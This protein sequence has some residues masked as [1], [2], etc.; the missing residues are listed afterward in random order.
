MVAN[1]PHR[2]VDLITLNLE[3]IVNTGLRNVRGCTLLPEDRMAFSSYYT[4]EVN[5]INKDGSEYFKLGTPHYTFD[6]KYVERDNTLVVTSSW[7][8]QISVIC[9]GNKKIKNNIDV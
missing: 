1:F 4:N 7:E 3:R 8:S 9:M 6:V 5:V 2:S